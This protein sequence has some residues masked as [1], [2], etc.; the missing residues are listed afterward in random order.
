MGLIW[1]VVACGIVGL[2]IGRWRAILVPIV[3]WAGIAIFLVLNDGW[4]GDGWGDFGVALNV[5]AA[6]LS[7]L[8]AAVGVGVRRLT[9][10]RG[11]GGASVP[12]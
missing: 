2:L 5:I 7:L 3:L 10:R 11:A 12:R 8:A 1:I 9:S 4:Y 6:F